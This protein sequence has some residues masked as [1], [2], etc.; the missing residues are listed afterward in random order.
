MQNSFFYHVYMCLL[1]GALVSML[2]AQTLDTTSIDVFAP[3]AGTV[4]KAG[5]TL[6]VKWIIHA[7]NY[8]SSGVVIGISNNEGK[9]WQILVKALIKQGAAEYKDSIGTF[10]WVIADSIDGIDGNPIPI[11]A[12][13][14][15]IMVAAPYDEATFAPDYSG[16]FIIAQTGSAIASAPRSI[17]KPKNLLTIAKTFGILE[18]H[19][20]SGEL[21][22][23]DGKKLNARM[24]PLSGLAPGMTIIR[25]S[26]KN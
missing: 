24:K 20:G 14:C 8:P 12:T 3:K 17:S 2:S 11:A 21:Y 22:A 23:V 13:T 25:S 19:A 16:I 18:R 26:N 7:G 6:S 5:D 9:T 10:S 4:Y 1:I 15:M